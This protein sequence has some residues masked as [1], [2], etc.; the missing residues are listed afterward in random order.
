MDFTSTIDTK[1]GPVLVR[2]RRE[3]NPVHG[4]EFIDLEH[5]GFRKLTGLDTD[6]AVELASALLIAAG[7]D[8]AEQAMKTELRRG[9][10]MAH[11]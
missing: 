6:D 9:Q 11:R 1:A 8:D 5:D 3:G 4:P 2:L 7:C 10:A